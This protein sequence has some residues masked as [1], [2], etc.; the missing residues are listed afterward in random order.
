MRG[1]GAAGVYQIRNASRFQNRPSLHESQVKPHPERRML[2][3]PIHCI[4][5][6]LSAHHEAR[7]R[8][9]P[10]P[11]R[12][13]DRLVDGQGETEIISGDNDFV[14]AGLSLRTNPI[15][16]NGALARRAARPG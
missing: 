3:G 5:A 2:P 13:Y 12:L 15:I 16:H 1:K 4:A 14:Q 9:N 6:K 10:P 8:E 11:V 7:R